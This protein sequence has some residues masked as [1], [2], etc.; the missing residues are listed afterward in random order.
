MKIQILRRISW[1]ALASTLGCLCNAQ[2]KV[3]DPSPK[4]SAL[5]MDGK[6]LFLKDLEN[7]GPIFLYFLRDGDAVARKETAYIKQIVKAYTP[8]RSNWY[9]VINGREDRARSLAAEY[10]LPFRILRDEDLSAVHAFG[11]QNS[12]AVVQISH[13]GKILGIWRGFSG[14]RLKAIN[15]AAASVNRRKIHS[16]DFSS[17][18][19]TTEYGLDYM[20]PRKGG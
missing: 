2:V 17:T 8:S 18:P 20:N 16:I 7:E 4:F 3:G 5:S 14:Y 9:A 6:R 10:A 1:V 19:S 13:T 12:P 15:K 11:I